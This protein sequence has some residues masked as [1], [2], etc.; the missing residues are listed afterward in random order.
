MGKPDRSRFD[1]QLPGGGFTGSAY[2]RGK[3]WW[4]TYYDGSVRRRVPLRP[5]GKK[6]ATRDRAVA[7]DLA[8]EILRRLA[9]AHSGDVDP[10][11]DHRD[12]PVSSHADAW[13][14]SLRAGKKRNTAKYVRD[15]LTMLRS[16]LKHCAAKTLG[17]LDLESAHKW[18]EAE[19]TRPARPLSERSVNKRKAVLKQWGKWLTTQQPP[20]WPYNPFAP[21]ALD[22]KG[23]EADQRVVRDAIH[24]TDALHR[25]FE[26]A[27]NF[28]RQVCYAVAAT[29]GLRR[30]ELYGLVWRDV[31]AETIKVRA[32]VSK[33][34]T[35]AEQPLHPLAA[36][37]LHELRDRRRAGENTRGRGHFK[38]GRQGA[39]DGD[40]VFH[41]IPTVPT[42]R[43]ALERAGIDPGDRETG[44]IDFHSL[45]AT[46]ATLLDKEG[47]S[48]TLAQKLMRHS[49]PTLTANYYTKH[50]LADK[51][52]A[53]RSVPISVP[54]SLQ[55]GAS[56][57]TYRGQSKRLRADRPEQQSPRRPQSTGAR[58]D[59]R[60]GTRTH[61]EL[62]P[63]DF[64][65]AASANSATRAG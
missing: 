61:K 65:S 43:R 26:Q 5:K 57:C 33:N 45:R 19:R 46:F 3:V 27:G 16:Y 41:A 39:D 24:D 7:A 6:Q 20:R 40:H 18:L 13:E 1:V 28:E 11:E 4:F 59:T 44:C 17:D 14:L 63:A 51:S 9:R 8:Q 47:V 38:R 12:A 52:A 31:G 22:M 34:S 23:Q 62:P 55:P 32:R 42:L 21:L 48:L 49:T 56:S 60:G 25:L 37:L 53:V 35:H 10:F 36:D 2:R 58:A 30:G 29:T 54:G 64:E 15:S 50:D